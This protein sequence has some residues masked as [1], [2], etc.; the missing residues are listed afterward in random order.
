MSMKLKSLLLFSFICVQV[1]L[2]GQSVSVAPSR[3]YYKVDL[4][5]YKNQIV[6]VTNN[7]ETSQ[8][9]SVTFGDFEAPG[10]EGKSELMP[11]GTSKHGCSDW[12]SADPSFFELG[13]GQMQEIRI[14]LQVPNTPDANTVR[15]ATA[16]IKLVKEKDSQSEKMSEG[17][18]MGILQTFQFVVH[19]FQTPPA[20]TYK[21]AEILSFKEIEPAEGKKR[22][23]L[24]TK[25]IG[26]AILD[27]ASYI[28]IVS[29]KT[30]EEQRIKPTAFTVLPGGSREIKFTLPVLKPGKYS[31]LGVVD[32]GSDAEIQAAEID[33]EI[34]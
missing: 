9:F 20:I 3:L 33:I 19:V 11:K 14:I 7:S 32:Y 21:K 31:L 16:M 30:G 22:V 28:E 6:R 4:G 2:F 24:H 25:N 15:W 26:D 1:Q 18:G 13:P 8:S 10:S 34:K 12:L 5:D 23:S 17:V 27:C 29:L